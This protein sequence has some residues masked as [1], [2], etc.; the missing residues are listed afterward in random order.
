[1]TSSGNAGRVAALETC[2]RRPRRAAGAGWRPAC[3][4]VAAALAL[5]PG[6]ASAQFSLGNQRAGTSAVPFLKLAVG[7]RASGLGEA[8]VAVANDPTAIYW[9]PAGLA[10]LQRR[11][12]LFAH[13]QWPGDI[14]YEYV[15]YV[16]P[17]RRF[18]GSFAFQFGSLYTEMDETTEFEPMGT[19]RSFI[20]SDM[21]AGAAYARR[22]TDKLL[23]GAGAKFVREDAGSD[24][25]G[26]VS[27]AVL[28]DMG[29][30]YYLGYGSVRIAT[31][32]TNFG[33]ALRPGGTFISPISGEERRY[34]AFDPP[35]QFRYG[36]AFEPMENQSQR[37]TA[38]F[39]ITQPA[40]N[41]QRVK[42]GLE[43]TWDQRLA[44]RTG[45][46]FNEDEMKFAAGAGVHFGMNQIRGAFD[47]AYTNGGM[48]GG[49]NRFSLGLKF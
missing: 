9:N 42:S 19:G 46:S 33:P 20:F 7:A 21:V 1:M 29:S 31:S 30:I 26:P 45:Y 37:L 35:I 40:D 22:W 18:G 38:S 4:A 24:V 48:L 13:V 41:S 17:S 11:E 39:E 8:F 47:Y 28:F 3:L 15:A 25:G 10:S 44:L 5:L 23:V 12:L 49:V 34:D 14:R 6:P 2:A 32:L 16:I 43:W 36:F 27:Q